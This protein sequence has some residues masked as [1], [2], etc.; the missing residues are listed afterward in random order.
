MRITSAATR[1]PS[2][3]RVVGANPAMSDRERAST[4]RPLSLW[5]WVA[6]ATWCSRISGLGSPIGSRCRCGATWLPSEVGSPSSSVTLIGTSAV[7]ELPELMDSP[8]VSSQDRSPPVT[9]A[10]TTSLIVCACSART[11]RRSASRIDTVAYRRCSDTSPASGEPHRPRAAQGIAGELTE[12]AP[13]PADR[14]ADGD[15]HAEGAGQRPAQVVHRQRRVLGVLPDRPEQQVHRRRLRY[16][17]PGV[18][19][20]AVDRAGGLG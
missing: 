12:R 4:A 18:A 6:Y 3:C 7:S 13:D 15:R 10:R 8:R 20:G 19:A 1:T 11:A 5:A 2:A 9:T 17:L 16:R 14:L